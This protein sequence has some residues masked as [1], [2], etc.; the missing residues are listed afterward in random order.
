MS[1]RRLVWDWRSRI[2]L[3]F[4]NFFFFDRNFFKK[5]LLDPP[6]FFSSTIL[7]TKKG[8]Y[9]EV[10]CKIFCPKR[11]SVHET[12]RGE[13]GIHP[14]DL[15][16]LKTICKSTLTQNAWDEYDFVRYVKSW[17]LFFCHFGSFCSEN[18]SILQIK[19]REG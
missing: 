8:I 10:W 6:I 12:T 11:N 19:L 1:I 9:I 16:R 14:P 3:N 2:C 13:G 17:H 15:I 5:I 7:N 18:L 4:G